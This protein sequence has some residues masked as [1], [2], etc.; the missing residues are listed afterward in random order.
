M[1]LHRDC[2]PP[3]VPRLADPHAHAQLLVRQVA[4]D[5]HPHLPL[6]HVRLAVTQQG[7]AVGGR[8]DGRGPDD[9]PLHLHA[10][11][12]GV[13]GHRSVGGRAP[14][15]AQRGDLTG[16]EVAQLPGRPVHLLG[17]E[18]GPRV[19]VLA[20]VVERPSRLLVLRLGLRLEGLAVLAGQ[21]VLCLLDVLVQRFA[22]LPAQLAVGQAA[23]AAGLGP[24]PPLLRLAAALAGGAGL[25]GAAVGLVAV[26]HRRSDEGVQ[27]FVL[28]VPFV[29][30]VVGITEAA[31]PLQNAS[32]V[33]LPCVFILFLMWPLT[34]LFS[35][36]VLQE[37]GKVR[38]IGLFLWGGWESTAR[39]N[40]AHVNS[41]SNLR[42]CSKVWFTDSFLHG[43]ISYML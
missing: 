12:R 19:G 39:L 3:S 40:S 30:L 6:N 9:V 5:L 23:L 26:P 29:P 41:P 10:L 34:F 42:C 31:P 4:K 14:V 18:V 21:A 43:I 37:F 7:E 13:G 38:V 2:H 32:D 24:R 25:R 11:G 22:Q 16:V 35:F 8:A 36:D 33:L 17:L 1:L 28:E 27:K 15:Q 20:A